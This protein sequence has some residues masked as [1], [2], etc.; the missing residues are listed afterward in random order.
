M[1]RGKRIM[2]QHHTRDS[3]SRPLTPERR[4]ALLPVQPSQPAYMLRVPLGPDHW[5][6]ITSNKEMR[7]ED[8]RVLHRYLA[9]QREMLGADELA[10]KDQPDDHP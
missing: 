10:E 5:I 3:W 2:E 1:V 7:V 4:V 9:L 8:F 6:A